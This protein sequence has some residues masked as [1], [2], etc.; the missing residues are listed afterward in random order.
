VGP[1]G[2]AGKEKKRERDWVRSWAEKGVGPARGPTRLGLG[3]VVSSAC[4]SADRLGFAALAMRSGPAW[5]NRPAHGLLPSF[6]LSLATRAQGQRP[7]LSPIG[8]A[9]LS[10]SHRIWCGRQIRCGSGQS[11]CACVPTCVRVACPEGVWGKA[12]K[13]WPRRERD[14]AATTWGRHARRYRGRGKARL[15][16][17]GLGVA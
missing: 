14:V 3:F 1:L 2:Q 11:P 17:S 13:A 16:R 15:G 8:G 6:P 10:V 9:R 12:S 4:G 5:P 7:A